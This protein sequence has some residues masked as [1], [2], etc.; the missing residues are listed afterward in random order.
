VG[1]YLPEGGHYLLDI[2]SGPIQYDEYLTYSDKFEKRICC[3]VS[4][5]ALKSAATRIGDRGVYIQCD[6]TNIPLKDR[7]VDCFVCLHTIY[8][9]PSRK[10]IVAFRELERVTRS[11]GSGVVVYS[12]GDHSWGTKMAAPK[13]ALR[14]A[15]SRLRAGLRPFL[16]DALMTWLRGPRPAS[17]ACVQLASDESASSY[18]FHA[19]TFKWYKLNIAAAGNWKLRVWRTPGPEFLK[20]NISNGAVGLWL[21]RFLYRLE[22][23][24]PALLGRIGKYPMFVFRKSDWVA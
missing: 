20:G 21:L 1:N 7:A 19:H 23:W 4:F 14:A 3:D 13:R 24:F 6:I 11:G 15:P 12:W 18:C 22:N 9:V 2:A 16:P 8:H 5:E 10:Q 17:A